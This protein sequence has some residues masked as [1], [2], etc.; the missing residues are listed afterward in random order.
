MGLPVLECLPGLVSGL[1]DREW[2]MGFLGGWAPCL[3][4]LYCCVRLPGEL[5][6]GL[7]VRLAGFRLYLILAVWGVVGLFVSELAE[8]AILG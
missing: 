6:R 1:L 7:L 3:L 4:W 8:I 2:L 5:A